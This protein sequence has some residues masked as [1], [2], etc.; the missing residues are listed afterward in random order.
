MLG[1]HLAN[2]RDYLHLGTRVQVATGNL[3]KC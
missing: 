2:H 1:L 3:E